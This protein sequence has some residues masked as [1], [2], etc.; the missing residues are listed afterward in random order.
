MW[1]QWSCSDQHAERQGSVAECGR[2]HSEHTLSYGYLQSTYLDVFVQDVQ[3]FQEINQD[4]QEPRSWNT[5]LWMN[6]RHWAVVLQPVFEGHQIRQLCVDKSNVKGSEFEEDTSMSLIKPLRADRTFVVME[7]LVSYSQKDFFPSFSIYPSF[8]TSRSNVQACG[9]IEGHTPLSIAQKATDVI[10]SYEKYGLLGCNC[11]HFA[12][13]LLDLLGIHCPM[14]EDQY[15]MEA[16]ARS[17]RVLITVN[18]ICKGV[19]CAKAAATMTG[20]VAGAAAAGPVGAAGAA[21]YLGAGALS[22][23]AH[24][25]LGC[26]V[27]NGFFLGIEKGY[28]WV[29]KKHRRD[30]Q[31]PQASESNVT[32]QSSQTSNESLAGTVR[33]VPLESDVRDLSD[34]QDAVEGGESNEQ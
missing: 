12:K 26:A 19:A 4:L 32:E 5:Y 11:Q 33:S 13:D 9:M 20:C 7:L 21:G 34:T 18:G 24:S 28:Q 15:A 23:T 31:E 2:P 8:D 14:P 30:V 3:Q 16:M 22:I 29:S 17:L 10:S 1:A 27:G 25:L 6:R